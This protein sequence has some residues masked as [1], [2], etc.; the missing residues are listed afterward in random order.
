MQEFGHIEAENTLIA[1][2]IAREF[3]RQFRLPHS[4]R[5]EKQER[6]ERFP[7]GLQA[8]LAAFENRANAGNHM[9]LPFDPGKQVSFEAVQ[10]ADCGGI[11]VHE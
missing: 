9:V 2:K 6:T 3:Q 5:P 10:V 4:G 7:G 8:K 1:E 11:C